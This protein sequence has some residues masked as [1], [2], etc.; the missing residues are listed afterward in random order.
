MTDTRLTYGEFLAVA[1]SLKTV[2]GVSNKTLEKGINKH[3]V[4]ARIFRK[5][6]DDP[7]AIHT[8][9][10]RSLHKDTLDY[11]KANDIQVDTQNYH[12]LLSSGGNS[13]KIEYTGQKKLRF[14]GLYFGDQEARVLLP[15]LEKKT[16]ITKAIDPWTCE[17]YDFVDPQHYKDG[18]ME[19][20]DMMR[21]IWGDE[22]VIAHCEMNAFKY[23]V[24]VGKKPG[25]DIQTDLAKARWYE[26]KAIELRKLL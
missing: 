11:C 16:G 12:E 18:G 24:R 19:A 4:L 17:E 22:K 23:R 20:I 25:A 8:F 5:I 3:G 10:S 21:R 9:V 1:T 6:K 26:D 14:V 15:V 13:P 2:T 7:R